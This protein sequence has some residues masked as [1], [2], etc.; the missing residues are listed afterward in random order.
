MESKKWWNRVAALGLTLGALAAGGCSEKTGRSPGVASTEGTSQ[1]ATP[2]QQPTK[3][4]P[5]AALPVWR[6]EDAALRQLGPFREVVARSGRYKVRPPKEYAQFAPPAPP[7]STLAMA[8]RGSS[9]PDGTTPTFLIQ[10]FSPP[11]EEAKKSTPE[12]FLEGMLKGI[13]RR[14]TGWQQTPAE[15]GQV[16]GLT[17]LRARWSGTEPARQWKMHGFQYV[18]QDG[19]S[20]IQISSQDVE[21]HHEEPL[22]LAEVA[23]LTFQRQ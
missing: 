17:M 22:R 8:W 13:A 1:T 12:D 6:P 20:F 11:P 2:L 9:R 14:R 7:P 18:A 3:P 15:S 10:V 4:T 23:A 5:P 21:P 19:L 16:N